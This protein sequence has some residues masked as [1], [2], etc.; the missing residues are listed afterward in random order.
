MER[1]GGGGGGGWEVEEN[2]KIIICT[3][4]PGKKHNLRAEKNI[5]RG[6]RKRKK[7][8]RVTK[9]IAQEPF[10]LSL[11]PPPP[12]SF[13]VPCIFRPLHFPSPAQVFNEDRDFQ[14]MPVIDKNKHAK[15]FIWGLSTVC[16]TF[17]QNINLGF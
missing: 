1:L 12:P 14:S 5:K 11:S 2:I 7:C 16:N 8:R 6:Y 17:G 13:S 10:S 15:P 3:T 4:E 9:K